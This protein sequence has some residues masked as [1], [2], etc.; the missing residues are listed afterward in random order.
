VWNARKTQSVL[1]R[2]DDS[3]PD[4]QQ[5]EGRYA[6]RQGQSAEAQYWRPVLHSSG[7]YPVQRSY[8]AGQ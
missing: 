5:R 7:A 2:P 6:D 4:P 1:Y 3:V 8:A